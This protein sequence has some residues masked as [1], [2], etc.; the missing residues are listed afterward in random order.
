M[1]DNHVVYKNGAKEIAY[2]NGCS[3][4][5]MAKPFE[6]WIGNSC[7]IHASLFRD[8]EPAFR[9]D[10][11]LFDRFLAGQIAVL[12]GA[13][14]LPGADD[15]LVQALRRRE[16]GSDDAGLGA[17]QPHVRLPARRSRSLEASR[18]AHPGWRRQPVPRLRRDH[19]CRAARHRERARRFRRRSRGTRTSRTRSGFPRR[20][21][22][23]SSALELGTMARAGVR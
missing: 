22:R 15:Q 1:A 16:L 3:I 7:H 2:L 12:Q 18:D 17:G 10:P 13:R 5:F 4:T 20:C 14:D 23:R 19:R 6:S 9:D 21:V 8:G 11:V